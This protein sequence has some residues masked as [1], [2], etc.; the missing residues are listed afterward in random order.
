[1]KITV[2]I[3]SEPYSDESAYTGLKF[4][5]SA[6]E[7]G[8]SVDVFLVQSGVFCALSRQSPNNMPNLYELLESVISGGARVVYCGTCVKSR[9]IDATMIHPDA[10]IGSMPM[11][12]EMVTSSDSSI[13]F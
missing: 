13:S 9:G 2:V 3:K 12:V 10:E 6:L 7:N 4:I 11:F 5:K 8:H 1:M